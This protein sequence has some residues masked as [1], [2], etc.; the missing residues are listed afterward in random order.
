MYTVSVKKKGEK[1]MSRKVLLNDIGGVIHPGLHLCTV[2]GMQASP[3][4]THASC[5]TFSSLSPA[6]DLQAA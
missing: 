5:G 2:A 4:R 3:A 6:W 1:G